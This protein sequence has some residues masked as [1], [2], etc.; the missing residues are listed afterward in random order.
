MSPRFLPKSIF[1]P[2]WNHFRTILFIGLIQF[3]GFPSFLFSQTPTTSPLNMRTNPQDVQLTP[4]NS[5]D[6]PSDDTG[7]VTPNSWKSLSGSA[8]NSIAPL[9]EP[10]HSV[11]PTS[12]Q[13]QDS[14]YKKDLYGPQVGWGFR[15]S[16]GLALQQSISATSVNGSVYQNIYFNPGARMD[17]E[18]FYN[19][20]NG[21]YFGLESAF[22]YNS[23][24]CT[25]PLFSEAQ[26]VGNGAFYQVP[27]LMNIR[28]QIP[29]RGP[30]RGYCTGGVGGV[31]DYLTTSV[32]LPQDQLL[33]Y[34]QH[35]WNYAFQIGFGVQYNLMPGLDLDTSFKTLITPNPLLFSDGTS[36]VKASYNYALQL[37]ISYRF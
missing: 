11:K 15:T 7:E 3:T 35:Q 4:T 5:G 16:V 20:S 29:N 18:A 26:N 13:K 24:N 9:S 30:I 19:V 25:Y 33:T 34:S 8:G 28:F 32:T 36:Q 21:F 2:N 31:W 6:P 12:N 1:Y 27:I 17:F 37:G 22:V 10:V 23:L 14:A